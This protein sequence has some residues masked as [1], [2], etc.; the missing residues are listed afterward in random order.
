VEAFVRWRH[1]SPIRGALWRCLRY[2]CL[3]SGMHLAWQQPSGTTHPGPHCGKPANP[4]SSPALDAP[5]LD[6]GAWLRCVACGWNGAR[7]YAAAI[8]IALL[9]VAF[10]KQSLHSSPAKQDDRPTMTTKGLNSESYR[11]SGL[12]RRVPPTSPRGRLLES[13]KLFVNGWVK[14]VTL[15]SAL[16]PDHMLRLCA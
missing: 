16:P 6:A 15:H 8:N 4:S 3:L 9:G 7:D 2:K 12:A 11:G 10:L 13:G 1:N 14:A 5:E